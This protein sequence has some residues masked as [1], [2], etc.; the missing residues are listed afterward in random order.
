MTNLNACD[1]FTELSCTA[2]QNNTTSHVAKQFTNETVQ[3]DI[4]SA[5]SVT[6]EEF[7]YVQAPARPSWKTETPRPVP[8]PRKR[9]KIP[10]VTDV[11]ENIEVED[12]NGHKEATECFFLSVLKPEALKQNEPTEKALPLECQK[13]YIPKNELSLLLTLSDDGMKRK[14]EKNIKEFPKPSFLDI[15]SHWLLGEKMDNK[16]EKKLPNRPHGVKGGASEHGVELV[17]KAWVPNCSVVILQSCAQ[18]TKITFLF[19]RIK[20]A[21][22]QLCIFVFLLNHSQF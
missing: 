22:K 1:S 6:D 5:F 20:H 9:S 12:Q 14:K 15:L 7:T 17:K 3:T 8:L 19:C 18:F 10:Q 16:P 13:N 21:L 11:F 2:V 4:D